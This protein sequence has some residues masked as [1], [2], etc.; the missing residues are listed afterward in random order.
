MPAGAA[1]TRRAAGTRRSEL[2]GRAA[3]QTLLVERAQDLVDSRR[4][5]EI[6]EGRLLHGHEL[7]RVALLALRFRLARTRRLLVTTHQILVID[8]WI[9]EVPVQKAKVLRVDTHRGQ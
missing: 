8:R 7:A 1:S 3:E 2:R 5:P 4:G 9:F 6:P